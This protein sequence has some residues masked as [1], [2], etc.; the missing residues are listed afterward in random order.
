V[1]EVGRRGDR[2]RGPAVKAKVA[3]TTPPLTPTLSH[4]GEREFLKKP[5]SMT[6][7]GIFRNLP[8][9]R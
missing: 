7:F 3:G 9:K 6:E 1:G 2:V 4:V 5:Q 8:F